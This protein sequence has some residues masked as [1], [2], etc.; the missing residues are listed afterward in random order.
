MHITNSLCLVTERIYTAFPLQTTTKTTI[1]SYEASSR[2]A[3][4][5]YHDN[6]H[7][8]T[9]DTPKIIRGLWTFNML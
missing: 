4:T 1:K 7:N 5:Q 3:I 2:L 6:V 9:G 8:E